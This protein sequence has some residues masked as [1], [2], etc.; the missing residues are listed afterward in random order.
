MPVDTEGYTGMVEAVVQHRGDL[1]SAAFAQDGA[2]AVRFK[3]GAIYSPAKSKAAGRAV[4]D[5]IEMIRIDVP[6]QADHVE[7]PAWDGD[8]ARFPKQYAAFKEGRDA[9]ASGTPLSVWP[10]LRPSQV[11]ELAAR[12]VHTVEQLAAMADVD[13]SKFMG[14]HGIRQQ[15]R[16]F[17]E[18]AKGAAPMTALRAELETRD[19]EI[20]ALK[21]QMAE[22]VRASAE[23]AESEGAPPRRGRPPKTHT[24]A[25]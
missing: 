25:E 20:A 6:G 4:Y 18:A 16:D 11:A 9:L 10:V 17:L 7:R 15:A 1:Q 5:D 13:A 22:L 14:M 12:K 8:R 2:L 24:E 19:S 23:R 3:M 21:A